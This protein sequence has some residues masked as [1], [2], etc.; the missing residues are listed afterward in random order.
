MVYFIDIFQIHHIVILY[1]TDVY[2][3]IRLNRSNN[4]NVSIYADE[5][6]ISIATKHV[7]IL[8]S[9]LNNSINDIFN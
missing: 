5:T 2:A 1:I 9:N 6:T 7:K 3:S 8:E 4:N